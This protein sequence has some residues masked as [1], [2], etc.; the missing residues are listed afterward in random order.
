D[1]VLQMDRTLSEVNLDRVVIGQAYPNVD[2]AQM[3]MFVLGSYLLVKG[4]HTFVNLEIGFSPE[5]F[6]E[7]GI[8]LGPAVDPVPA[9]I[10]HLSS[11]GAYA[12]EFQKGLVV[13]NPGDTSVMY[14]LSGSMWRVT[15]VGGG[16][17]PDD[18]QIP[19]SW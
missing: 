1:W 14:S 7:Y 6:P 15:P 16:T 4:S 8:D 11:R 17:V 9:Q 10:S 5:W 3:R 2:D 19:P 12:R 13:V 18:G